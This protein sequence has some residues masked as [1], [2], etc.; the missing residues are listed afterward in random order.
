MHNLAIIPA[1]GG[2]KRIPRKNIK[3]FLGIP[4]IAYSIKIA[5]E[6]NFFDEI[7]VSTDDPEIAEIAIKYGA[8]VPFMR[9]VENSSDYSTTIEVITEVID[10]YK[11][12]NQ[13]FDKICCI[14]PC[15]PLC[16]VE[17]LTESYNK[18]INYNFETVFPVIKYSTPIQRAFKKTENERI[19]IINSEYE[20]SRTQD[21][22]AS[23]FDAGQFYW[24]QNPK[25]LINKKIYTK[26]SGFIVLDELHAQDI[27]DNID[28]EL[29]QLKYKLIN[30]NEN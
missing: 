24:F 28:W 16:K 26:N 6:S 8:K 12:C 19:I 2:S 17:Y 25:I 23:Y 7:M 10:S 5:I 1:R 20:N 4:I 22:D 30:K 13:H 29:A 27:D 18:L 11:K 14:Y 3:N 21:L 9:S 15:A